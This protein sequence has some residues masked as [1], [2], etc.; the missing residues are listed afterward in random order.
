MMNLCMRIM[1]RTMLA[2]AMASFVFSCSAQDIENVIVE[3]YYVSDASDATD[4]T[5]GAWGLA[6]GSVTYRI[7]LD[8][9][10]SCALRAVYGSADHPLRLESTAP[11][12]NHADL[13]GKI[14]GHAITN[15]A[16][17]EGT[18]A[19]DSWLAMGGASNQRYGVLKA[20]DADGSIVGGANND[21]GSA[22]VAGGLLV[23]STTEMG[24]A[25]TERDGLAPLNG[26][27]AMPVN[28]LVQGDD[29][30]NAFFDSLLVNSFVS[31]DFRMNC[32]TP[33]VKGP[34]ATNSVIVAQIT[35]TGELSFE[36]NVEVEH[37]DGTVVRYV[38]R[39]TLLAPDETA[40]GLLVYPPQCGCTDPD[41]L[42]YDPAA[43]CDDGSCATTI[44]FGCL[45]P[46]ACNYDPSANFNV[47][48]LCC[49]GIDD[50]NGLDPFIVC[51]DVGVDDQV[52]TDTRVVVA[53]N[54]TDGMM[55]VLVKGGPAPVHCTLLDL[56]GRVVFTQAYGR[57]DRAIELDLTDRPC[58]A[59]VLLVRIDGLTS[60]HRIVRY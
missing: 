25:L 39:D 46:D 27:S 55:R 34:T 50:C 56:A 48:E 22:E 60:A 28:F 35:T 10:D 53:P 8:L 24:Y 6:E 41:F 45:D 17:D 40:N 4:T 11:I 20:E 52:G 26:G 44:V 38:A 30:D 3:T 57:T 31:A 18:V 5:S 47:S 37:A 36:L 9:C 51:P 23:N 29:P 1:M 42:E 2:M 15:G 43:G 12:F 59:Y 19:L 16:L 21:G 13:R 33:G 54:P 7:Y 49:Y 58:G 14:F 32:A